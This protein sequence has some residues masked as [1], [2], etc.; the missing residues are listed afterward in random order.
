MRIANKS[1][2]KDKPQSA[3][4]SR[5]L[6]NSA[7]FLLVGLFLGVIA[8]E[9]LKNLKSNLSL[10]FEAESFEVLTEKNDLASDLGG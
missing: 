5:Y 8:I 7:L 3:P 1:S 4:N 9:P 10:L 6:R 2:S